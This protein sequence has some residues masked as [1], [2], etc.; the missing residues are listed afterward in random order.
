M[1]T[2]IISAAVI[3]AAVVVLLLVGKLWVPVLI[4]IFVAALCAMGVFELLN[5]AMGIKPLGLSLFSAVYSAIMVFI[6]DK[7][8]ASK[9]SFP[10]SSEANI[11]FK[12]VTLSDIFGRAPLF[13]TV[14]YFLV[15]V[16]FV[17][18]YQKDFDLAKILGFTAFPVIIAYGFSMLGGIVTYEKSIYY[19][20]LLC[21]FASI[22]DTGAY[23][24]GS[25]FGK[26]K[27]CPEISPKKTVEGALGGIASSI[28]VSLI[29]VLCF[30]R[31]H[32]LAT[33]LLTIPFCIVGMMG[34][35][36]ASIIKRKIG[37]KD[38]SNLIPGHG[39]ILD[40]FDSMLLVAPIL[41]MFIDFGVI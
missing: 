13:I 10:Y 14:F 37:I 29:L 38:Y 24:V 18:Y 32:I 8:I 25:F 41:Y 21:N 31:G 5:N 34:D 17:L 26:H 7:H 23:F 4:P 16:F 9:I 30:G 28:V 33:L 11:T 3:I 15:A 40:R 35:L 1:K 36:F 12:N 27:L 22:S 20:L 2:R 39:G 6:L 19:L